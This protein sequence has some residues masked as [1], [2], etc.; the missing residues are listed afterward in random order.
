MKEGV[1]VQEIENFAKKYKFQLFFCLAFVLA[2]F[3]SY[4]FFGT[5]W[6]LFLGALGGVL[7]VVFPAYA[8]KFAMSAFRFVG[9]QE[10][11]TQIVLGVVTLVL[12]VFLPFLIFLLLGLMGG[13]A[14]TRHC[15]RAFSDNAG[16]GA[17]PPQG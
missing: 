13:I 10:K 2:C 1:S 4:V 15:I 12:A 5:G 7:G 3:F 8:E 9:K 11:I 14:I 16:G 17:P 6:S